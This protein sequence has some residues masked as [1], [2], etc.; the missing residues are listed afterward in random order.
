MDKSHEIVSVLPEFGVN[1]NTGYIGFTYNDDSF[2][3]KGIAWF[4]RWDQGKNPDVPD[5][6]LS[7]V[8]V[9][10]GNGSCA[11]ATTPRSKETPLAEYFNDPH[12]HIFFRKPVTWTEDL[13]KRISWSALC[14]VGATYGYTSI[15]GHAI[16]NSFFGK[17][18]GFVTFGLTTKAFKRAFDKKNQFICS[19]YAALAMQDQAEL[20][21]KGVLKQKACEIDPQ[22]LFTDKVIFE[23]WTTAACGKRVVL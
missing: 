21:G 5:V 17:A 4:T 14:R 11:E 2:I 7:H 15:V 6:P 19:E 12:V 23:P 8:V 13:G 16:A 10:T 3:S 1:Y 18:L 9:V 20:K 22:M